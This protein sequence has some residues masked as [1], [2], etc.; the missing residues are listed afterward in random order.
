MLHTSDAAS[1]LN[2]RFETTTD[3]TDYLNL[4]FDASKMIES[5]DFDVTMSIY[6]NVSILD[7]CAN[8][9]IL[10]WMASSLKLFLQSIDGSD[11]IDK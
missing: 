1:L 2:G 11:M 5:T 8:L 9:I 6:K 7:T 4:A 3:V 10:L